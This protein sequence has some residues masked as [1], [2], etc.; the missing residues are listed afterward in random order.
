MLNT[1]KL[2]I[3]TRGSNY[4]TL[5]KGKV[6]FGHVGVTLIDD[7]GEEK[8]FD[9]ASAIV[10]KR[11]HHLVPPEELRASQLTTKSV[12]GATAIGG[13]TLG[14]AFTQAIVATDY[15]FLNSFAGYFGIA[16]GGFLGAL[17]GVWFVPTASAKLKREGPEE[18]YKPDTYPTTDQK[19][20]RP[21]SAAQYKIL[22]EEYDNHTSK[23]HIVLVH[24]CVH[25]IKSGLNKAGIDMSQNIFE[26][27]NK[28]RAQLKRLG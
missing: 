21:I 6:D 15:N 3:R 25:V 13:A 1:H 19:K 14:L 17:N 24:N 20:E 5:L 4:S 26:T 8:H 28:F 18:T 27:P 7:K 12:I 9:F 2:I 11:Y 16:S 23:N 10:H 22:Y